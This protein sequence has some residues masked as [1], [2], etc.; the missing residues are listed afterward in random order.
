MTRWLTAAAALWLLGSSSAL[1]QMK[2]LGTVEVVGQSKGRPL[3]LRLRPDAGL[4][5]HRFQS[6]S[7]LLSREVGE[8]AAVGFGMAKVYGRRVG[9]LRTGERTVRTRKPAVTFL[10]KF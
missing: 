1:A 10:F 3:D 8:N 9:D 6:P 7:M 2:S 5:T 4:T